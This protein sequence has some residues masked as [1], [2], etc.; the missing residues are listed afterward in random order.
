MSELK[1]CPF[2]GSKPQISSNGGCVNFTVFCTGGNCAA[3]IACNEWGGGSKEKAIKAWDTRTP[4]IEGAV[5]RLI[6]DL[7]KTKKK[8][9][10]AKVYSEDVLIELFKIKKMLTG[11]IND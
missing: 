6:L 8:G 5:D 3:S 1:L 7:S 4:A 9:H 10:D 2:C 11:E